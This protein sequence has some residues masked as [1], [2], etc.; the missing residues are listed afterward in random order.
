MP[1]LPKL[2]A[3]W[4]PS[5]PVPHSSGCMTSFVVAQLFDLSGVIQPSKREVWERGAL[6]PTLRPGTAISVTIRYADKSRT[7]IGEISHLSIRSVTLRL[8]G[9]NAVA[10]FPLCLVA[11]VSIVRNQRYCLYR[12]W[13]DAQRRGQ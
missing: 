9:S 11:L 6:V 1:Y 5:S 7:W 4:I 2:P 12:G 13:C 3:A 8:W 10:A